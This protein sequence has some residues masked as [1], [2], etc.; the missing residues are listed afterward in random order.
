MVAPTWA[1]EFRG[2]VSG[3]VLDANGLGVPGA[4]VILTNAE[5]NVSATT[6]TEQTGDYAVLYLLPGQ[7]RVTVTA[8]GFK[9]LERRGIEV[10]IGD[11]LA[12]DLQLEVGAI[13]ETLNVTGDPPLL[14]VTSASPGQVIDSRRLSELPLGDGNPTMLTRIAAGVTPTGSFGAFNQPFSNFG[15]SSIRVDGAPGENEYTLNGFPNMSI[16]RKVAFNTPTDAVTE[17]KMENFSYDAQ[18]GHTGAAI[19]NVSL[20]GGTNSL[21]G[22]LYE[23]IRN[24]AFNANDFFRNRAHLPRAPLRYDRYGGSLSGPVR[25]PKLYDGRD[26]TFFSFTYE[27]LY[28]NFPETMTFSVPTDAQRGGDFRD[29]LP[30]SLIYDPFTATLSNGQV[31]RQQIC[32]RDSS[33]NCQPGTLNMIDPARISP[34]AKSYLQFIPHANL[35]GTTFNLTA[36]PPNIDHFNTEVVRIDH[37]VSKNQ[38]FFFH[39]FHNRLHQLRGGW[40]TVVNGVQ[41]SG[42]EFFRSN[43]GVGYDHVYTFS[44]TTVLDARVGFSRFV[45]LSLPRSLGA[46]DPAS[47]GFSGQ[48]VALFR[49]YHYVPLLKIDQYLPVTTFFSGALGKDV[50]GPTAFNIYSFQPALTKIT[51]SHTLRFGYDFRAY[52]QNSSGPGNVAGSYE[53]KSDFTNASSSSGSQFGQSLASFLLGLPTSGSFIDRNVAGS[54][55]QSPYHGIFAQDDWRVSRRLTLNLGLRWEYEPPTTERFNRNIRGFDTTS[56]NPIEAAAEAAYVQHPDSFLPVADFHVRGGFLFADPEHR[57]IWESGKGNLEPRVGAAYRLGAKTVLRGGWGIFIVPLL[58]D[59]TN[60]GSTFVANQTGFSQQTFVVPSNDN[61]LTFNPNNCTFNCWA[62]PFPNG[63]ATPPGSSL[64]LATLLGQTI[65]TFVPLVRRNG[66]VQHWSVDIQ[67]ELPRQWLLDVGYFATKGS[68][69]NTSRGINPVPR[70]FLSTNPIR[71]QV[72]IDLLGKVVTNPFAGLLPGSTLNGPQIRRSQLLRPFPEFASINSEAY[73]GRSNYNSLQVRLEKRFSGGYTLLAGY[74]W[75]KLIEQTTFLNDTDTQ[76]EKRI[77]PNDVTHRVVAS[78]VWEL[79]FGR[80]RKWGTNWPRIAEEVAGGWQVEAIYSAQSGFPIG[81]LGNL[82]FFGDPSTLRTNISSSTVDNAFPTSGFYFT[83]AAVQTNGVPDP[84][85]QRS[86]GRIK[87]ESNIRTF[88]SRLSGFRGHALNN[89]DLSFIKKFLITEP[90]RLQFR[91]EAFN[92]FNHPFFRDPN[93]DPT[94]A[95]FGKITGQSNTGRYLQLGLKLTF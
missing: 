12:L 26:K 77:S 57:G 79:P 65:N 14:E 84:K 41:P 72:A 50:G 5:T 40:S 27:G 88:P 78:G 34:I 48:T 68:R 76:P 38:K 51:G 19:I 54:S 89:W 75:S 30:G 80:G 29:L 47:M 73:V 95:S 69:L 39:Y 91:G 74:T 18:S 3:R 66:R 21:H 61:G 67:K 9:K 17:F 23:F 71:D 62:D 6:S 43:N 45:E 93:T 60:T 49:G 4:Q 64:G 24:D 58:S 31:K 81:D 46:F 83:D 42:Q 94:S 44:P 36:S 92:L 28:D 70:Q 85:K 10:R 1:Q 82:V 33:G 37:T 22:T 87:L 55:Y 52:R 90:V 7:Y 2:S 25:I 11:K 53:F 35:S 16:A 63:A 56:S 20:K 32:I 15:P 8:A 59:G 86:D 13:T